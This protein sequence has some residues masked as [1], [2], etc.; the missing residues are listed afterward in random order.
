ML[1]TELASSQESASLT[2]RL[3]PRTRRV[4]IRLWPACFT[5]FSSESDQQREPPREAPPGFGLGDLAKV[6]GFPRTP[7]IG[8]EERV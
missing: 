3:G 4:A 7:T 5:Y 2:G 6:G 1:S 8:A